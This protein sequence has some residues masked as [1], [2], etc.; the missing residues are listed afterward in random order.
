M[1]EVLPAADLLPRA[2]ELAAKIAQHSPSAL[3]RTKRVIWESLDRGLHEG[4]HHA[5]AMIARHNKCP[6]PREGAL[7]FVEK[8]KPR[9]AP[10]TD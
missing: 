1:G 2:R 6:D 9:W 3:A 10:Y 4:L 5:W 7:A 8:R